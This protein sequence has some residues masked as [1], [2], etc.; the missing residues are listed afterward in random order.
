MKLLTLQELINVT[1][2]NEAL[3]ARIVGVKESFIKE[4]MD[5]EATTFSVRVKNTAH[6]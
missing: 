4:Y 1:N 6:I 5:N 3:I 2:Y